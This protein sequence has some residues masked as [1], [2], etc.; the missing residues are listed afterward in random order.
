MFLRKTVPARLQA[1][2]AQDVRRAK[3][4]RQGEEAS[5]LTAWP[6]PSVPLVQYEFTFQE[7][8]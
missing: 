5:T 7:Y 1:A 6:V 2:P 3:R 8:E 4:E